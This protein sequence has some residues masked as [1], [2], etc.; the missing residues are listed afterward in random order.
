MNLR[1]MIYDLR[2][3]DESNFHLSE[4]ASFVNRTS[5]ILNRIMFKDGESD[6]Q[7]EQE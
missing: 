2:F 7:I 4:E 6:K 5:E 3:V 1:G